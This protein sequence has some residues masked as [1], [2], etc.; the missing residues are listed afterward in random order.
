MTVS[1]DPASAGAVLTRRHPL[2]ALLAGVAVPGLGFW[3]TGRPQL[4]LIN[5]LLAIGAA[6]ALPVLILDGH[7]PGP[8]GNVA[9]LP[10]TLRVV[11]ALLWLPPAIIA[12]ILAA[13]D[14]PRQRRG[15]EHPWWVLGFAIAFFATQTGLRLR[16]VQPDVFQF[17]WVA[18][19]ALA[20]AIPAETIV[21]V[22]KRG[23]EAAT[24]P[25]NTLVAIANPAAQ[26]A[27]T[28]PLLFGRVVARPG[29]TVS[30]KEGR[31]EVDGVAVTEA[32]CPPTLPHA[33]MICA[34]E[35]QPDAQA[36]GGSWER[37]TS[38]SSPGLGQT[39]GAVRIEAP[40]VTV[41][42]GELF[43]LPDDRR[44]G[45]AGG[46]VGRVRAVDIVGVVHAAR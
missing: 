20:P 45:V 10:S 35:K 13:R 32:P 31:P 29:V 41:G 43:L 23:V 37:P 8:F 16:V 40:L 38:V 39:A 1:A 46:A 9:H 30:V 12:G 6:V 7:V 15:Y 4:A 14:P 34:V 27:P 28:A 21:V 11:S 2:I 19:T 24:L 33:G 26:D 22:Q 44:A 3:V 5:A 25:I 18:D 17:A 42:P 36:P